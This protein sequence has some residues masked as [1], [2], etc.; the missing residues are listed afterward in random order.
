M[1]LYAHEV[2][3]KFKLSICSLKSHDASVRSILFYLIWS[4]I[5]ILFYFI[6]VFLE[7]RDIKVEQNYIFSFVFN[8]DEQKHHNQRK[9][10]Y[11]DPGKTLTKFRIFASEPWLTK[12]II[13]STY[14]LNNCHQNWWTL[15]IKKKKKKKRRGNH[16]LFFLPLF[17]SNTMFG[18]G[19]RKKKRRDIISS[20]WLNKIK[21]KWMSWND[22]ISVGPTILAS[23]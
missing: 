16:N 10:Q 22:D 15:W 8:R 3:P 1:I 2:W 18:N 20:V 12:Y 13:N 17:Y 7:V 5:F 19:R 23:T 9:L 14:L 21:E 6:F 4:Y 11:G